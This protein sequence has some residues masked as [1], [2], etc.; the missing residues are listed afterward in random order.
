MRVFALNGLATNISQMICSGVPMSS[1]GGSARVSLIP[2]V[3][4]LTDYRR[5]RS[6]C[7]FWGVHQMRSLLTK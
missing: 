2:P 1:P 4:L 3:R 5:L 6:R 7:A